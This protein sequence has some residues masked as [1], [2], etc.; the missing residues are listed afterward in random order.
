MLD[1]VLHVQQPDHAEPFGKGAGV[2]AHLLHLFFG[3]EVGWKHAG[4]IARVDA[5]VLDVLHHPA[6]DAAITVRDGIHIGLEGVLEEAVDEHGV[7][8]ARPA[9]RV[10]K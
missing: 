9:R 4:R 3:D 5:G 10:A 1:G 6:D 2:P 7:L 8:L